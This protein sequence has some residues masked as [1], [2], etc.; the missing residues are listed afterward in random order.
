MAGDIEAISTLAVREQIG[1]FKYIKEEDISSEFD[2]IINQLHKEM[3]ESIVKE[4]I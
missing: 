3:Q 4:E 1:R 2:K